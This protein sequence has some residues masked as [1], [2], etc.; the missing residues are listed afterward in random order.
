MLYGRSKQKYLIIDGPNGIGKDT[1]LNELMRRFPEVRVHYASSKV[2]VPNNL[3]QPIEEEYTLIS[4][5]TFCTIYESMLRDNTNNYHVQYRSPLTSIIYNPLYRPRASW[6]DKDKRINLDF[7]L[8]KYDSKFLFLL[9]TYDSRTVDRLV[10]KNNEEKRVRDKE[11]VDIR[12][13][14]ELYEE[15]W[16]MISKD[17]RKKFWL[18]RVRGPGMLSIFEEFDQFMKTREDMNSFEFSSFVFFLTHR[19]RID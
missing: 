1:F 4:Y 12:R 13:I 8:E 9:Y 11:Y 2:L 16:E 6:L 19:Y 3:Y 10:K 5:V 14:N 18:E 17:N 15:A 7:M